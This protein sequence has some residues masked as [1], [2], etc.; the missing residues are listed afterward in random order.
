[1]DIEIKS[2]GS[3]HDFYYKI[4]SPRYVFKINDFGGFEDDFNDENVE[5]KEY[6]E[7]KPVETT[8][9][10]RIGCY[11]DDF[12]IEE[13]I[14]EKTILDYDHEIETSSYDDNSIEDNLDFFEYSIQTEAIEYSYV[15]NNY[16][17]N[18]TISDGGRRFVD[19]G[20]DGEDNGVLEDD[21]DLIP[22]RCN[23]CS[24]SFK[25]SIQLITHF[26]E[27]HQNEFDYKCVICEE[28][29]ETTQAM[30]HHMKLHKDVK[31]P[32][33]CTACGKRF[34]TLEYLESHASN[35]M[36]HSESN[37][38]TLCGKEFKNQFNLVRH[39]SVHTNMRRFKCN[40]C[41]KMFKN[42]DNLTVHLRCHRGERPFKVVIEYNYLFIKVFESVYTTTYVC[43]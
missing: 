6:F 27:C 25:S 38:C 1:M 36:C 7:L 32:F 39:R 4:E 14:S 16:N 10:R 34:K 18:A 41:G 28:I 5:K 43:T 35:K 30:T 31:R 26:E 2:G 40:L 15:N 21:E 12:R 37:V 42:Q 24:D 19:G 33:A 22:Y 29:F 9:V 3:P 8:I 23:K 17:G 13:L 11:D 20:E